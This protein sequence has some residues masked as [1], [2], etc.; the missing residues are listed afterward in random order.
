M[1][2]LFE[3]DLSSHSLEEVTRRIIIDDDVNETTAEYFN[4]LVTG[5]AE[6]QDE[7]DSLISDAAPAYPLDQIAPIDRNVLRIAVYELQHES[8]VPTKAIIN[9]AVEIAKQFGGEHS[10]KFV[11]GVAGSIARSTRPPDSERAAE[12]SGPED[13]PPPEST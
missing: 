3:S 13:I 11:N 6:N 1:Q 7:I 9:E 4:R 10:S 5:I 2:A 8:S 12:E